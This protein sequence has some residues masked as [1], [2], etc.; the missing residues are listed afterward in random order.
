[1][2]FK[3]SVNNISLV[4]M[5]GTS[6]LDIEIKAIDWQPQSGRRYRTGF[7]VEASESDCDTCCEMAE[8]KSGCP[9]VQNL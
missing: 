3:F 6:M 1:M 5:P 4:R 8:E 2:E 9:A 7:K